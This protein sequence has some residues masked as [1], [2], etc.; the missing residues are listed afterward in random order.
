MSGRVCLEKL[1]KD[2]ENRLGA[3]VCAWNDGILGGKGGRI[4]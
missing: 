3:L 1:F 2:S 4:A